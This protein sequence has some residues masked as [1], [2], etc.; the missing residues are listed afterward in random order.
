MDAP[1]SRDEIDPVET[2]IRQQI[3]DLLRVRWNP[4]STVTRPGAYDVY[5]LPIPP[6]YEGRWEVVRPVQG[7][8][9]VIYQVRWDGD[10]GEA[11]RAVGWWLL[12]F[13]KKWDRANAHWMVEQQRMLDEEALDLKHL[14]DEDDEADREWW[15]RAGFQLA[16]THGGDGREHWFVPAFGT[17]TPPHPQPE[18][19]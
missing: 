9:A 18:P 16:T 13:L 8:L 3:D 5:G 11:Y 15:D 12:D 10:G 19:V 6:Q 7:E 4:R 1:Q 14:Q 2:A 17:S